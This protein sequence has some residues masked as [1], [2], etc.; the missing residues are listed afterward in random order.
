MAALHAARAAALTGTSESHAVLRSLLRGR[1]ALSFAQPREFVRDAATGARVPLR[2]AAHADLLAAV[3]ADAALVAARALKTSPYRE[4]ER[5]FKSTAS[6]ADARAAGAVDV[7]AADADGAVRGLV[8]LR[9]AAP[10]AVATSEAALVGEAAVDG[11]SGALGGIYEIESHPGSFLL[12]RALSASAQAALARASL[13]AYV[14]PPQLRNVDNAGVAGAGPTLLWDTFRAQHATTISCSGSAAPRCALDAVS[15]ATLGE[16]Y[17]WTMRSYHLKTDGDAPA[18]WPPAAPFPPPLSA[19]SVRVVRAINAATR[20]EPPLRLTPEAG[21]VNLYRGAAK[22]KQPMGGHVDDGER[23]LDAPVVSISVGCACVFLLGG[24]DAGDD[25]LP[26]LLHSGD[27]LVISGPSRTAFHGVAR[28][29]DNEG[30]P[31]L[32]RAEAEPLAPPA[33]L[34]GGEYDPGS[35]AEES[36]FSAWLHTARININVRQVV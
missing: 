35:V 2:R 33:A 18:D 21:I 5:V 26:V 10:D 29:F 6:V 23:T 27:I 24:R 19:L 17:D 32:F 34:A 22:L 15:W 30:A 36:A 16:H 28:V 3:E 7:S 9:E 31:P 12:P 20:A 14:E 4:V 13:R 11:A 1:H 25:P 8:R